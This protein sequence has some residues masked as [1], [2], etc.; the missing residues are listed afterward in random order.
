MNQ[1]TE[2]FLH[3]K[4]IQYLFDAL[5][6]LFFLLYP[7]RHVTWGL[8]LWD[9][10][11]N[12]GNF[13]FLY[14]GY[15]DSMWFF[16]TYLSEI[17]GH[18]LTCL[19]F[20]N[21]LVGMNCYT[22]LLPFGL[23][24]IGYFFCTGRLGINRFAAFLG[25]EI[26]LSLCWCP[27]AKL[28]DYLTYLFFLL[29][30]VLVYRGLVLENR[31]WLFL[32]GVCLGINVFVR[33]SNLPEVGMILAVWAFGILWGMEE[34]KNPLARIGFDT[35]WC[36][37]GFL[38]ALAVI[39]GFI[40][41][42]YGFSAYVE[43]IQ[44]LFGMTESATDYTPL[45]MLRGMI[46]PYLDLAY[47]V[48]RM[49]IFLVGATV[50]TVLCEKQKWISGKLAKGV[51]I[52]AC[53]IA[54]AALLY[55][56][57]TRGFSSDLYYSYDPIYRPAALFM[58]GAM[59]VAAIRILQKKVS[60]PEK[61]ISG[62]V[63]LI[64]LLSALGSNNNIY[65][66][67]N[68]LFLAGP[69]LL[70]ELWKLFVY[71]LR[72]QRMVIPAAFWCGCLAFFCMF[73]FVCFGLTFQFAEATGV[74]NIG[75]TVENVPVLAGVKMSAEKAR[76]MQ[77]L[78]DGIAYYELQDRE[79]VLYGKIPALAYY[80]DMK[81]ASNLWCILDSYNG[82]TMKKDLDQLSERLA[83]E[84]ANSPV[85][86]LDRTYFETQTKEFL[87]EMPKDMDEAL[88]LVETKYRKYALMNRFLKQNQYSELFETEKF[89]VYTRN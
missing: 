8:D 53:V 57:C 36:V 27:T 47:W 79:V 72:K 39:L 19:P 32:A 42:K 55:W 54:M 46:Y 31:K 73:Q 64:L 85:V 56:V 84:N 5:A 59:I 50:V 10:G 23:A 21:T 2:M 43:G 20:G 4:K 1:K 82:E 25:E 44:R 34:K 81:P 38:A 76:W 74:Q 33:F 40:S 17:V 51:E 65:P 89:M 86:I 15:R 69:Y 58:L 9:T 18:V 13:R 62:M 87:A 14:S 78:T 6:V 71:G 24:T 7:L 30:S 12:Y 80:L 41:V 52:M 11:Y 63:I 37:L 48:S 70:W 35:L 29:A 26:A 45:A 60:L 49:L 66:S 77:D 22:A 61:L 3:S 16:S 68:N 28:Y 75:A 83:K 88:V 67:M